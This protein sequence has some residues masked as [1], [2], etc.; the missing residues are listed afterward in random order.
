M[1]DLSGTDRP[2]GLKRVNKNDD[3]GK[4]WNQKSRFG[5]FL[6]EQNLPNES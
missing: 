5:G 2:K 1:A 4:S 6:K 3:S